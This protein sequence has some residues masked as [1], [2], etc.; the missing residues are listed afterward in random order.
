MIGFRS[1]SHT[2]QY[3]NQQEYVH[4]MKKNK[5][6]FVKQELKRCSTLLKL[7]GSDTRSSKHILF[8]ITWWN[9]V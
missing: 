1:S 9:E 6:Q 5:W 7:S 8:Y 4:F 2:K 3:F